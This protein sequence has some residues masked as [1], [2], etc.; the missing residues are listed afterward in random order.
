[1]G[2]PVIK[3]L[4][5]ALGTELQIYHWPFCSF[6]SYW[7]GIDK[8][9]YLSNSQWLA[10]INNDKSLNQTRRSNMISLNKYMATVALKDDTVQPPQSAWHT[11]WEW[12]DVTRSKIMNLTDTEGYKN[13][14]LGLKT[15][16]ERGDL[17]LNS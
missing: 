10:D 9:T 8:H 5:G 15:L 11:Y 16:D 17:I 3:Q 2:V 7:R 14:V 12:G 13:D 4:C 6:C 1:M